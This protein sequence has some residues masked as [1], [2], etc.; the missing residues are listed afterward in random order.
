MK[1]KRSRRRASLYASTGLRGMAYIAMSIAG[2]VH[3]YMCP[4]HWKPCHWDGEPSRR[5][6]PTT[7]AP[8]RFHCLNTGASIVNS[9]VVR[10]C[11]APGESLV[12]PGRW[13]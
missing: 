1:R 5:L 6:P 2:L 11:Q 13:A 4:A 8:D 7:R 12:R 10:A 3:S 9:R